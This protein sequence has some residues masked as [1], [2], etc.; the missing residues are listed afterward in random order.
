MENSQRS[1]RTTKKINVAFRRPL[2]APIFDKR[3]SSAALRFMN[4]AGLAAKHLAVGIIMNR[5]RGWWSGGGQRSQWRCSGRRQQRQI[6][7]GGGSK[8]LGCFSHDVAWLSG[9]I[10][11]LPSWDEQVYSHSS[12]HVTLANPN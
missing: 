8:S 1:P 7:P 3:V 11:R 12:S 2:N 4:P 5:Y 9:R 10:H 6:A